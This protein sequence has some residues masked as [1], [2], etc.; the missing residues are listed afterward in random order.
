MTDLIIRASHDS[1]SPAITR[2]YAHAVI[3]GTA[4]WELEPPN[5]EEMARRRLAI[6]DAG[7]PYLV[8]ERGGN[9][10][11]YCY[12]SAYRPRA[13]YKATVEDSIYIHPDAQ[14]QGVGKALLGALIQHCEGLG[15]R[16]MVT[17]VGDGY[18]G[19]AASLKL[20][21]RFGFTVIGIAKSVGFKHGRWLDQVL[22]QKTLGAGD[23]TPSP[24][25]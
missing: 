9:V 21:E 6:V 24:F 18:G 13:A 14:G 8:A 22:M 19:S 15:Y 2:T 12:A 5:E 3:H 17:I 7:F 11:G 23:S 25:T 4:S 16:Q 1:D 20:H 10:L